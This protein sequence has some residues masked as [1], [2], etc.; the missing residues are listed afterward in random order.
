VAHRDIKPHN[1]LVKYRDP[2]YNPDYI[3][4]KL[5]DFGL[6]KIGSLKT[7]CGTRT[8]LPPEVR[9]DRP[10]QKYTNAVD[11][12]SLG[13][14]ILRLAYELPH[15]GSGSGLGWCSKIVREANSWE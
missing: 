11:I 5:S 7:W 15:T 12:W 3:H 2:G 4:V 1:I 9:K 6:S 14:V 10:L 13:L 8:Y